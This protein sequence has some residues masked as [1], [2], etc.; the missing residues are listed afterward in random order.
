MK[1][2]ISLGKNLLYWPDGRLRRIVH[3]G[4]QLTPHG[5]VLEYAADGTLIADAIFQHGKL[6]SGFTRPN[7]LAKN[8]P[9]PP[10]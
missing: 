3:V 6:I 7:T 4:P 9:Q 2:G 10:P 8:L 5:H 1:N